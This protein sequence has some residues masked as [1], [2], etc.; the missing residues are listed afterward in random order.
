[1]MRTIVT[2][3]F[4]PAALL[5]SLVTFAVVH[6]V[7]GSLELAVVLPSAATL[8]LAMGLERRMPFEPAWNQ[9]RGDAG[10]DWCSMAALLAVVDPLLKWGGP[11]LVTALYARFELSG[12]L[13]PTELPFAWQVVLAALIAEFGFYWAHRLHHSRPAL[14]W[15]HAL[16]H[17]SER[18]YSVNNFRLHPLNYAVNYGFG[19]LPLL[20]LGTPAEV[21]YGYLALSLPV[22]MLQHA[23][24]PL[25]SGWLNYVF[26]TN[27]VHRWH[28][29][30]VS[31]EGDSNFGRALV[32]WDQV[33][34]TYRYQP[35]GANR[36]RAIGLYQGDT[37]PA[38]ASYWRQ[39]RSML[40]PACCQRSA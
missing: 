31:G 13:F 10:T 5:A 40:S 20:A 1:A 32:L 22:L 37:Y 8:L 17:G 33:L 14:W 27:E 6:S 25:R 36:P 15:L 29:S 39:L 18:L 11:L 9:A 12:G 26:S 4:F 23:N 2:H 38:R 7:G 30:A 16:H 21:L 34:G 28:H 35:D 3:L 19:M 24:L